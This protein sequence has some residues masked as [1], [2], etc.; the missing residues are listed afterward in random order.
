[1]IAKIATVLSLILSFSAA[2]PTGY[3]APMTYGHPMTY[4]APSYSAPSYAAPSYDVS[5][6]VNSLF[7]HFVI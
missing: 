2:Q 7:N 5:D 4:A 3:G 1:M 6:V